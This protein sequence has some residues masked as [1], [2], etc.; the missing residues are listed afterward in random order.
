MDHLHAQ[1]LKKYFGHLVHTQQDNS[2]SDLSSRTGGGRR[3]PVAEESHTLISQ[4]KVW[5][6]KLEIG[7]HQHVGGDS[8]GV[9]GAGV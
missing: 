8:L 2:D 6:I 4:V 5:G 3:K 7:D 1:G 9:G